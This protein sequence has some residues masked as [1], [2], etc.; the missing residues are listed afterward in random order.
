M[1]LFFLKD[2]PMRAFILTRLIEKN[3]IFTWNFNIDSIKNNIENIMSFPQFDKNLKYVNPTL[4]LG[5]E[6][7][8]YIT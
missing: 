3:N 2:A 1:L 4:F 7:S 8:N 6:K 5:G